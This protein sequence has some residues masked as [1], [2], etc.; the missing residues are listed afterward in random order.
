[1]KQ[2]KMIN[3]LI[4]IKQRAADEAETAHASA[5]YATLAAEEC[6]KNAVSGWKYFTEEKSEIRSI[7]DLEH[8][9]RQYK[10]LRKIIADAERDVAS[11]RNDEAAKREV[12][13][14]ARI[15]LRRYETWLENTKEL[16]RLESARTQRL[17]DDEVA[18]RKGR[19]G[20]G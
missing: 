15:E 17:A 20:N 2:A 11:A 10:W 9:D 5:H 13:T 1:M 19:M 6:L 4:E 18:A 16:H 3:R 12:M 14:E 7:A 8:R